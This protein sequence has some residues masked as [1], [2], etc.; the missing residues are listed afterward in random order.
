MGTPSDDELSSIDN[1]K[2]INFI[3]NLGDEKGKDLSVLF[4]NAHPLAID[5][6][7]KMLQFDPRRRITNTDV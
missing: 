3:K 6:L 1:P 2:K 5:L 4:P 7:K